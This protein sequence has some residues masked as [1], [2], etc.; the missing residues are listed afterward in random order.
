LH[1]LLLTRDFAVTAL[2]RLVA[3]DQC[4]LILCCGS[5]PVKLV[6]MVA[7]DRTVISLISEPS[8]V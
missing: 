5:E 1:A 2:I 7:F 4:Q 8:T 3:H 6:A